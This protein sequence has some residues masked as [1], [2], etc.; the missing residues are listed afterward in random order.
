MHINMVIAWPSA[1]WSSLTHRPGVGSIRR[2]RPPDDPARG[3]QALLLH[4]VEYSPLTTLLG[5][6]PTV[7]E[8]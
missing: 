8:L 1:P 3:L 6:G 5:V 2:G 4:I 7:P